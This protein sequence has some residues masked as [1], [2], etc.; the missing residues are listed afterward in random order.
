MAVKTIIIAEAGVNH[1]GSLALAKKLI[2]VAADSGADYVKFQTFKTELIISKTAAKADYQKQNTSQSEETQF[3][4]VKK[5]E[6]SFNDFKELKKYCDTKN[7]GFLSTGFDLPSI[8][9]LDEIGQL[10]FKIPSGEITNKP[11]LQHIAHKKKPVVMST[12]MAD[13]NEIRAALDILLK[14]GLTPDQVTILHCNTEYPTPMR[15]VNLKAMITIKKTFKTKTGYSDHTLGIEVPI[16]AV[17]LG[18]SVIEKHYT[19]D[20]GMQGPDHKASLEP[21]ELKAMVTAIRNIEIAMAGTGRKKP[22]QSE[23]KNIAIARKS[24]HAAINIPQGTKLESRHLVMKRPGNGISP[25]DIDLVIGR[26]LNKA[27]PADTKLAWED[28]L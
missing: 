10:F 3:E 4:M 19:L 17:A 21:D 1:N 18:A 15:D 14:E 26:T 7:I 20:R 5:L 27:I 28:F 6:L 24:I 13:I 12:G 9:F 8:D 2:D 11:Y 23:T 25:M 22:S 16:A